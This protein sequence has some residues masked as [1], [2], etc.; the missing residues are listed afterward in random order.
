[1]DSEGDKILV[2]IGDK[3]GTQLVMGE[4]HVLDKR[5]MSP[6]RGR[7]SGHHRSIRS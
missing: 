5:T 1:M 2:V 4:R 7:E 6:I 3:G